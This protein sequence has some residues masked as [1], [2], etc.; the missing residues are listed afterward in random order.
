MSLIFTQLEPLENHGAR[1]FWLRFEKRSAPDSDLDAFRFGNFLLFSVKIFP[2][3][4]FDALR[5]LRAENFGESASAAEV[6]ER[7]ELFP[8]VSEDAFF[9]GTK[10]EAVEIHQERYTSH[11]SEL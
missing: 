11:A 5:R 4:T 2:F 10:W 7:Y 9:S 6:A 1:G 8:S 3:N